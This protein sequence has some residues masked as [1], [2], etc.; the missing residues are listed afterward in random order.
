MSQL[1]GQT[2]PPT[3]PR[4]GMVPTAITARTGAISP[5]TPGKRQKQVS[6][7]LAQVKAGIAPASR[8]AR[9]TRHAGRT[10]LNTLLCPA[11]NTPTTC[12]MEQV[13]GKSSNS[14][15]RT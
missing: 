6:A 4:T 1:I 14:R 10:R 5:D 3:R 8:V 12:D 9:Q 7:R 2:R 15:D 13:P 11:A